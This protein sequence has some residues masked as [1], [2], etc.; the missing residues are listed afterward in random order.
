MK[1]KMNVINVENTLVVEKIWKDIRRE[2][3]RLLVKKAVR[4]KKI[5]EIV[6]KTKKKVKV[7]S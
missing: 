4:K 2:N 5:R 6:V 3:M 7:R 1:T